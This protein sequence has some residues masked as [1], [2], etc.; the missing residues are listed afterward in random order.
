M[1]CKSD[2]WLSRNVHFSPWVYMESSC[3]THVEN[4]HSKRDESLS[5]CNKVCMTK[6][7]HAFGIFLLILTSE[8]FLGKQWVRLDLG[9]GLNGKTRGK[10]PVHWRKTL[11]HMK[12][13]PWGEK[14]CEPSEA[15]GTWFVA[16]LKSNH[17]NQPYIECN[18]RIIATLVYTFQPGLVCFPLDIN[19]V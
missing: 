6:V 13:G 3:L 8:E 9:W 15:G 19:F 16:L 2:E 17:L 11:V 4:S 7:W 10:E 1:Q 18:G 5:L 14:F 12:I